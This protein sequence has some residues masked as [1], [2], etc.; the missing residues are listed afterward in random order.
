MIYIFPLCMKKIRRNGFHVPHKKIHA[1]S[2][3]VKF[4]NDFNISMVLKKQNYTK[5]FFNITYIFGFF[6]LLLVPHTFGTLSFD[7]II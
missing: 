1:N 5:I 6:G 7:I 2:F 4:F 3:L